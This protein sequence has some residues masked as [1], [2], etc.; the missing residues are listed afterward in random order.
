MRIG[1]FNAEINRLDDEN[2]SLRERIDSIGADNYYV[3]KE[4]AD[5][6]SSYSEALKTEIV[7]QEREIA[8]IKEQN[9]KLTKSVK[10]Q[11]NKLVKKCALGMWNSIGRFFLSK[12]EN[13]S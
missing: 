10:T 3:V 6:L 4:M 5:K 13:N 2:R 11:T 7:S 12:Q 8:A 9:A 1:E